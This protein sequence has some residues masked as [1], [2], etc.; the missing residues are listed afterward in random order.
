MICFIFLT[1]LFLSGCG[2][3]VE[4]PKLSLEEQAKADQLL[5]DHGKDVIVYYLND[6]PWN[7]DKD[8]ILN[9]L[10]YFVSKRADVNAKS[11]G[12]STPLYYAARRGNIEVTA[13][14]IKNGL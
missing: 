1:V 8:I 11:D 5:A 2:N 13:S 6:A 12:G 7:T 10:K 4:T 14:Q 3:K 9:H